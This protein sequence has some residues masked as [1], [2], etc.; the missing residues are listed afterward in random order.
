MLWYVHLI[1]LLCG[2]FKDWGSEASREIKQS[3]RS[4][5]KLLLSVSKEGTKTKMQSRFHTGGRESLGT[6]DE[7][8]SKAGLSSQAEGYR[9]FMLVRSD[10]LHRLSPSWSFELASA[11]GALSWVGPLCSQLPGQ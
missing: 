11:P 2:G 1:S 4:V 8:L 3:H 7:K 6:S 5:F 10:G 9:S